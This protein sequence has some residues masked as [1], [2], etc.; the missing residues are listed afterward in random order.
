[1]KSTYLVLTPFFPTE[2]SF[3]GPFIFD[4]VEAIRRN[5]NYDLIV[6]KLIPSYLKN[7]VKEYV[8]Q[9]V[10]VYNFKVLDIPSF[11]LPGLFK[12]INLKRLERLIRDIIN[13][14]LSKVEIIHAHSAYPAGA[15][16]VDLGQK[17]GV[18]SFVQHH[19]F[20]VMQLD[21]GRVLKGKLKKLN[22]Q[23]IKNRFLQTVNNT[24]LNIGVSQKI[25]DILHTE[26]S[27]T[28]K[29]VMVLFNGV[30][31][32]KFYHLPNVKKSNSF[33]IGCIA[34]FWPLKDHITLLKAI[35]IV[36]KN[37]KKLTVKFIGTG[38]TLDQC[39]KYIEINHLQEF[40][41]F[42]D[43]VDHT[44]L[45]NFYNSLDLFVLPSYSEG[46]GCV[47]VEALQN[48]V[49][50]IA[51]RGQGIEEVLSLADRKHFLINKGDYKDL[52]QKIKSQIKAPVKINYNFDI[53]R[54]IIDFLN[55]IEKN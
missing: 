5:S 23:Y 25:I 14:D 34:N 48:G 17:F 40:V 46:F 13:I 29:N 44:K 21:N 31:A 16:A 3:H 8:Y 26:N 50:I 55:K 37:K 39:K 7:S 27:F 6:I 49:P 42:N 28:N 1:M 47:Y 43:E 54:L 30:N 41:E 33:T 12:F 51:V 20:D 2:D 24:D 18:K 4:Q 15:L 32:R 10:K 36:V 45:N 35:N 22:N 19:G 9:G 52:A 53:D 38:P 11:V